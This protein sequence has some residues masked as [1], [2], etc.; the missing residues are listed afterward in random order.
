MYLHKFV[1]LYT[2]SW[3]HQ[4]GL[5]KKTNDFILF[6]DFFFFFEGSTHPQKKTKTKNKKERKRAN[7]LMVDNDP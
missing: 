2:I 3:H 4:I 5:E 6:T 7:F 1:Y